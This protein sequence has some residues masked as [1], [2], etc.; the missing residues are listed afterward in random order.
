MSQATLPPD[1]DEVLLLQFQQEYARAAA[2]D[3]PQLLA[4][5]CSEYPALARRFQA[6]AEMLKALAQ[7]TPSPGAAL[8]TK[9]GDYRILGRL[10]G[11]GMGEVF[12]GEHVRLPRKGIIKTI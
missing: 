3:R 8:P 12:L 11:G 4:R 7:S 1:E 10:P 9:L 5:S 6:R 2:D